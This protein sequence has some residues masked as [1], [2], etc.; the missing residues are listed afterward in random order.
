MKVIP[1]SNIKNKN[2]FK[3]I[4][5]EVNILKRINHNKSII[6]LFE[7]F[8]DDSYVYL[9]F[10]YVSEGDLVKYFKVNPLLEEGDLKEF[11]YKIL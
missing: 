5:K 4:Q 8:Q 1:R 7:V 2:T 9:V 3:K 6:K 10:E 11:F